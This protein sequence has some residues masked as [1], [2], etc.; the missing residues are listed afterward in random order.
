MGEYYK[1]EIYSGKQKP[2]EEDKQIMS[3]YVITSDKKKFHGFVDD[4]L[5]MGEY[6][7]MS[8]KHKLWSAA[9]MARRFVGGHRNGKTTEFYIGVEGGGLFNTKLYGY[10]GAWPDGPG[11]LMVFAD[12]IELF[13]GSP[14]NEDVYGRFTKITEKKELSTVETLFNKIFHDYGTV[15]RLWENNDYVP[16]QSPPEEPA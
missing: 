10:V 16:L 9:P 13:N 14:D 7:R 1:I 2:T 15:Y 5:L 11:T 12:E 8:S 6:E 3:G 4:Y